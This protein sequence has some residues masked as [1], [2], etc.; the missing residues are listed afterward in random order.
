VVVAKIVM[1]HFLYGGLS[2]EFKIIRGQI[3]YL[4]IVLIL[5]VILTYFHLL[6][7]SGTV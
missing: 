2:E 7:I 6:I 3:A 4:P 5:G 1:Y